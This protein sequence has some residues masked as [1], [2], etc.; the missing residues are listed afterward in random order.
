MTKTGSAIMI[1]LFGETAAYL[2]MEACAAMPGWVTCVD[3][4][5]SRGGVACEGDHF[6]PG[7]V[8]GSRE[9]PGEA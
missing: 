4:S 5:G 2:V 9:G 1:A 6:V 3:E 8:A 7:R